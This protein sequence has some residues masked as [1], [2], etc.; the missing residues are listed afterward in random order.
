MNQGL[1]QQLATKR[2]HLEMER[3]KEGSIR[4]DPRDAHEAGVR[5][6]GLIGEVGDLSQSVHLGEA[7]AEKITD[8]LAKLETL[9]VKGRELAL[10]I[11]YLETGLWRLRKH[12]GQ[13]G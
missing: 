8:A 4:A 12:L 6:A 3:Q 5:A 9:P 13:Q 7:Q 1:H 11:T 10:A 2:K